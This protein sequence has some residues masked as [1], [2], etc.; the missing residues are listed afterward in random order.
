MDMK[1]YLSDT[2][3]YNDKA[4]KQALELIRQLPE[5]KEA[6]RFFG[7]LISCQNKWMARLTDDPAEPKMTWWTPAYELNALEN[8]WDASLKRWLDYIDLKT[9]NELFSEIS[10]RGMDGNQYITSAGDIAIQLNYHSIHH[11]AQIQSIIRTQGLEPDF[12]DY[13]G[14]KF[15]RVD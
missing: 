3:R 6:V 11:R 8:E 15:R 2:F 9:E 1:Q 5:K 14:L 7:H 4:N 13:I 12:V 10:L